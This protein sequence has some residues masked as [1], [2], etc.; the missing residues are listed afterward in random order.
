MLGNIA[1][2]RWVSSERYDSAG[3]VEGVAAAAVAMTLLM[4]AKL[5]LTCDG[6]LRPES[7]TKAYRDFVRGVMKGLFCWPAV[8]GRRGTEDGQPGRAE[9]GE[10]K[11]LPPLTL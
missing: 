5:W 4:A 1:A 8:D 6:L 3:T 2:L 10:E 11:P 7:P 9:E